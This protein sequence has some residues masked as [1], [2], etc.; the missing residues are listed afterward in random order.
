MKYIV[1]GG[2]GFIGSNLVDQLID[3]GHEV[4]ILDNFSTGKKE[5]CN[6]SAI[7][8]ELDIS[9]TSLNQQFIDIMR[10]S[11]GLFHVAALARVEESINNPVMYEKN[12]TTGTLNMLQCACDAGIKRFIYS[13]SSS[14]YGITDKLP[15]RENDKINPISPYAVQK[16]Y[17]EIYCTM[18]AQAYGLETASL[19]YFNVYGERQNVEDAY[20]L[21][22]AVFIKQRLSGKPL[23]IR[24]DGK[25]R[26]DFIHV[27]D[28]VRANILAM[29]SDMIGKGEIINI[30]YADNRS[31][32]DIA[33]MIGGPTINIASVFEPKKTLSDNSKAKML[34][35]WKPSVIIEEWISNYKKDLGIIDE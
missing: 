35:N 25:Q 10:D 21:V 2:A 29:R 22:I 11:D 17:G 5:N 6:N 26:R 16:Y 24:G 27:K 32:N 14:V 30:G 3:D 20:P 31:V 23:T 12:N 18:F 7:Y 8:H 1:T 9:N 34:L 33:E 28:V 13:S 4:H 19:R 15:S